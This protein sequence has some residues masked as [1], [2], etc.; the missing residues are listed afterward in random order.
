ME[1]YESVDENYQIVSENRKRTSRSQDPGP[2]MSSQRGSRLSGSKSKVRKSK[3]LARSST[4][5][6]KEKN[7]GSKSSVSF[8]TNTEQ[9]G[10]C[11]KLATCMGC[12]GI[13]SP[14]YSAI[15]EVAE[16]NEEAVIEGDK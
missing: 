8:Y 4:H 12:K 16:P 14:S 3:S 11:L 9:K 1:K 15:S 6:K 7:S 5:S 10:V 2:K 13:D